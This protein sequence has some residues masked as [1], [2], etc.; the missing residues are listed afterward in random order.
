MDAPKAVKEKWRLR[1][2]RLY[3]L[4]SMWPWMT[5]IVHM[6]YKMIRREEKEHEMT[7]TEKGWSQI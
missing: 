7:L 5:I 3:H 6:E 2:R 4:S 1:Q